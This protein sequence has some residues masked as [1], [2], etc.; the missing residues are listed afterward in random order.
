MLF[1]TVVHYFDDKQRWKSERRNPKMKYNN[2]K[3]HIKCFLNLDI[4][5]KKFILISA[6]DNPRGDKRYNVVKKEL[7][8]ICKEL[9]PEIS[10]NVIVRF[11]WGGTIAALWDYYL[12]IKNSKIHDKSYIAHFEEDF[13]PKDNSWFVECKR[14]LEENNN[15]YVGETTIGRV[16]REN[17]DNRQGPDHAGQPHLADPEV[18]TQGGL[19]FTTIGRLKKIEKKIGIFH[20]GNPNILYRHRIDGISIGEVGFPTLLHHNGFNF[21]CLHRDTYFIHEW[22]G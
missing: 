11:N 6:I 2:I 1:Y 18:W 9:L 20:K 5:D 19:R 17:D 3:K 21:G 15:I 16:K 10:F 13:G 8:N 22:C 4:K 14:L 7:T 12:T